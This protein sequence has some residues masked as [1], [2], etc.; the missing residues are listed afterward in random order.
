MTIRQLLRFAIIPVYNPVDGISQLIKDRRKLGYSI[1]IFLFLGIIYTISVQLAHSRGISA[2]VEPIIKIPADEYYY[3]Q[4]FWQ[5][6]FFFVTTIVFSGIVRLLAEAFG[7]EGSFVDIF[8]I[9]SIAQTFPMFLTMWLPETIGFVFFPGMS[10]MPVWLD[11]IRQIAGIIWPLAIV[12]I[13]IN[14]SENISW[15]KSLLFTLTGSIPM[16]A[17]MVIFVR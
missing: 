6:P 14:I 17:M 16:A 5:I 9:L 2:A 4:R 1:L 3:W 12:I 7:G 13:G 8:C 11:V 10:I 15:W